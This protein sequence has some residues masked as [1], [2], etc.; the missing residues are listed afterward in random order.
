MGQEIMAPAG[1]AAATVA[2]ALALML[3][4]C[5][6]ELASAQ[7]TARDR[8]SQELVELEFALRTQSWSR[9]ERFFSPAYSG[10]YS[11]LRNRIED[12]WRKE[13][14]VQMQFVVNRVLE[15][16]GL[17]NAQVRWNK[18]YL[19]AGS[20]PQKSSGICEFVLKPE[21]NGLQIISITGTL[22]F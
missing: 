15:R 13:R 2:L 18:S 12:N 6:M 10:G 20:R 17:L 21:G 5:G 19:D 16:D 3:Q 11:E 1:K 7:P 9:V 14:L 22:P 8:V 4:G